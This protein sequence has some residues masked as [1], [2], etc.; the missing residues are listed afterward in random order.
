[1][2][3]Q[4]IG[5]APLAAAMLSMAG[6]SGCTQPD[7][8]ATAA[9]SV[10]EADSGAEAPRTIPP[11]TSLVFS[12]D[13]RVSTATHARG[14]IFSA[15][16]RHGVNDVAGGEV[17]PEGVP[18]QWIITEAATEGDETVLAI[19]LESIRVNGT[20]TPVVGDVTEA[21]VR[22]GSFPDSSMADGRQVAVGAAAGELLGEVLG[23]EPD[24]SAADPDTGSAAS[25]GT[26]VTLTSRGGSAILPEG[27]AITVQLTEPLEV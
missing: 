24:G 23:E 27:S 18:S 7:E 17:I 4:G 12:V 20:W 1:M 6:T 2:R 10:G 5:C 3:W 11:G 15:T 22:S 19:R 25:P 8:A 14:D 21:H 13:V 16:L 9:R 26:M